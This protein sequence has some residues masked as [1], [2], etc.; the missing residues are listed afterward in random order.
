MYAA[1]PTT[2]VIVVG[3]GHN[4]LTAAC[5][6]ARAGL[7]VEVV[8]AADWI[9][10]CTTTAALIPGA[11][12]HRVNACAGDVITLR[13]STVVQ[14]LGLN[15][16]G[17]MEVDID[18][19]Y[20]AMTPDGAS[21]A[22]WRDH[23]RT[24]DEIRRFSVKDARAYLDLVRSLDS[25]LD[26]AVPMMATN[27]TRPDARVLGRTVAAAARHPKRMADV[28]RLA[29]GT[30]AQA[31]QER[32]EH[33][34]VQGGIGMLTTFG[35]P[36]TSDGSGAN[37]LVL[38]LLSRLGM[39]RPVN[40][41]QSL[42]DALARY[43]TARGGRIRT[44]AR[45]QELTT[46]AGRV[47]GVRLADGTQL[48]ARAVVT[49]CDPRAALTQLL[50]AGTLE[51]ALEARARHI[52][53]MNDGCAH[54]RVDVALGGRLELSR[55][56]RARGADIDLRRPTHMIGDLENIC[57]AIT[58]ARSGRLVDPVPFVAMLASSTDPSLAPAG[59]DC[60][61]LWSGWTPHRPPEGWDAL[62]PAAADAMITRAAEYYDGLLGLEVGRRHEAW[63][64]IS[65]RTNVPDGNVYHVDMSLLRQ[66]PLRPARGFGGYRTPVDGLFLTGAGTHPGPSVSGI[67]GQQAA[68]AVL[69]SL[70]TRTPG[71]SATSAQAPVT[72]PQR[73]TIVPAP[74]VALVRDEH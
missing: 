20:V 52:P 17:Y 59:Q 27:P 65:A 23:Q 11:P 39:G 66:G 71:A 24:A 13:A 49:S 28:A 29:T 21:L 55:H 42:P 44:S 16:L 47:T 35:S 54:F 10:G 3:A 34:M 46:A 68:R 58:D 7:T 43:L 36:I 8:E 50:P 60:L 9:G 22:F 57:D 56:T 64:D 26:A 2:D 33:P 18:P 53:T 73:P 45:V 14:D 5:Y 19:T 31:V 1:A 4:G 69:R 72:E 32:F 61:Y 41:V 63:P 40:G 67:P 15:D 30:A 70:G 74:A 37:L 48:Q 6:L 62:A 12:D 25:A 38:A 51:P